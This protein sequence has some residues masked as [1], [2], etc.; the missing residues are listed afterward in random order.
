MSVMTTPFFICSPKHPHA[1]KV[2]RIWFQGLSYFSAVT[3][4][5]WNDSPLGHLTSDVTV[6]RSIAARSSLSWGCRKKNQLKATSCN[7]TFLSINWTYSTGTFQGQWNT[8]HGQE[9]VFEL[10][11]LVYKTWIFSHS[12]I[13]MQLTIALWL[14]CARRVMD[15]PCEEREMH[16]SRL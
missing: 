4:S 10:E 8:L 12:D 1:Y 13:W 15:A 9:H 2:T 5:I 11:F 16:K 7:V 14:A 6:V 3:M